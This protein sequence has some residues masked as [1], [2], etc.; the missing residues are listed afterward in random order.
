MRLTRR[1]FLQ[2]TGAMAVYLGVAP[3]DRLL[4]ATM[5]D[6]A[7]H[8]VTRNK[9]LVVIFLRGGIDGLNWVV[10]YADADYA[11]LRLT[12]GVAAPGS[13]KPDP[14][15]DLDGYFGLNPR[16]AALMPWFTMAYPRR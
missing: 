11:K 12:I 9:T 7:K 10:P 16:C 2:S 14:A 4:A 15:I 3:I 13:G 6:P 1:F 8:P 5:D